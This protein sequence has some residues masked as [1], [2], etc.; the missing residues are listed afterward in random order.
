MDIRKTV[1]LIEDTLI[2]GGKALPQPARRVAL[3]AV[4][5]NPLVGRDDENLDE[6]VHDGE[7]LGR[8]LA[9]RALEYLDRGRLVSIGKGV[10]VG[11]DGEPEHGQALLYPKFAAA[12]RETLDIGTAP[13]QSVKRLGPANTTIEIN[14]QRIDGASSGKEAGVFELRV[15]GS[16]RDDEILVALV[17]GSGSNP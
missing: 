5:R 17:V 11:R 2:E 12:I 7:D 3:V 10:I 15:P 1:T 16:P 8:F 9:K 14:L 6:L 13:I 4:I